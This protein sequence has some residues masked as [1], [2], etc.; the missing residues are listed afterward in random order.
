MPVPL[1]Q[2]SGA[3]LNAGAG[4]RRLAWHRFIFWIGETR[5]SEYDLLNATGGL[6]DY[7]YFRR[8]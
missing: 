4:Q 5:S 8:G 2:R 7:A 6:A 3:F 1:R